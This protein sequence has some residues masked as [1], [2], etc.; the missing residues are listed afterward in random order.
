MG[1]C[2]EINLEEQVQVTINWAVYYCYV[3][4]KISVLPSNTEGQGI[5]EKFLWGFTFIKLTA[6]SLISVFMTSCDWSLAFS[7]YSYCLLPSV[8]PT[9]I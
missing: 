5:K 4:F 7:R 8:F 6:E 3:V 2:S 1:E 9:V